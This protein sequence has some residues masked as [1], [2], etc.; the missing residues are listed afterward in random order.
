MWPATSEISTRLKLARRSRVEWPL[1]AAC[2]LFL[3]ALAFALRRVFQDNDGTLVYSLDDA[4]IHMAIAKNIAQHG[5]WGCTPFHFSSS[6]SSLLWTA[7]LGVAYFLTGVRDST[8]LILN[9]V[10]ALLTLAIADRYLARWGASAGLRATALLALVIAGPLPGLVLLGMEHILHVLLT[11]WFAGASIALLADSRQEPSGRSIA[12]LCTVGALVAS[13]RYEGLFLIAIVGLLFIVRGWWMRSAMLVVTSTA[14]TV[15]FGLFS[16]ANGWMFFP[17]SLLLKAGGEDISLVTALLKPIGQV[18]VAFFADNDP[19]FLLVV[20]GIAGAIVQWRDGRILWRPAVLAPLLL[21]SMIVLHGHYT[22]TSMFWEYR[23][24]AYLTAFGVFAAAV[25]LTDYWTAA[26]SRT[27]AI[28]SFALIAGLLWFVADVRN[29]LLT[30]HEV[31]EAAS[32]YVGHVKAARFLQRYYPSA[33]VVVNDLGTVT[34]FTDAR[35]V[36]MF[37]LGDIEPIAIRRRQHGEYT[38]ADIA[39]WIAPLQPPIA[40]LQIGWGWVAPR[41]PNA[42]V[43]V[44]EI[45]LPVAGEFI[46]F[47]AVNPAEAAALRAHVQ[48]FYGPLAARGYHLRL[49]GGE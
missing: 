35:I 11:I 38:A 47:F 20:V 27:V 34:Y 18:D 49:L 13:S 36:D 24:A 2:G 17:N 41:I 3:A 32:N 8:P 28:A 48:E 29:A 40:I 43:R 33:T 46:G 37:G 23:Y 5:L 6:S 16:I 44:A 7:L 25:L 15:L 31:T 26:A 12:M 42:W 14:P 22:F 4:Y 1:F 9:S 45:E 21:A 10:F 19:L 39:H 30:T